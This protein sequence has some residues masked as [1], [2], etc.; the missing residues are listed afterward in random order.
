[1]LNYVLS[2]GTVA[3]ADFRLD[4]CLEHVNDRIQNAFKWPADGGT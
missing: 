3:G 2:T 1:M 4:S